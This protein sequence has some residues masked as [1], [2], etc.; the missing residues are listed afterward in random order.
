MRRMETWTDALTGLYNSCL[1][2]PCRG[3]DSPPLPDTA[4]ERPPL[5]LLYTEYQFFNQR[6]GFRRPPVA[7]EGH[8]SAEWNRGAITDRGQNGDTAHGTTHQVFQRVQRSNQHSHQYQNNNVL[9]KA[10]AP[11]VLQ[12]FPSSTPR[13][14]PRGPALSGWCGEQWSH[15]S[16]GYLSVEMDAPVGRAGRSSVEEMA[17][18]DSEYFSPRVTPRA[19]RRQDASPRQQRRMWAAPGPQASQQRHI[20]AAPGPQA[21]PLDPAQG[22]YYHSLPAPRS[23][24]L[25]PKPR[26]CISPQGFHISVVEKPTSMRATITPTSPDASPPSQHHFLPIQQHMAMPPANCPIQ[27]PANCPIQQHMAMPPSNCPIQQHMAMPPANCPIQQHMAMPPANC[28]IQQHMAVPPANR[29]PLHHWPPRHSASGPQ[30][31]HRSVHQPA[32][33]KPSGHLR[34]SVAMD[35]LAQSE[36]RARPTEGHSAGNSA[37][38]TRQVELKSKNVLGEPLLCATLKTVPSPPLA[39]RTRVQED[40]RKL[41]VVGD[42]VD[43]RKVTNLDGTLYQCPVESADGPHSPAMSRPLDSPAHTHTRASPRISRNGFGSVCEL[44]EAAVWSMR[45]LG[46]HGLF[47]P[48]GKRT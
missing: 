31:T 15:D 44:S 23:K 1:T 25:L 33:V 34:S 8:H 14:R 43:H 6:H 20:W 39:P 41:L 24:T 37:G 13:G 27:P 47:P 3:R 17:D 5:P 22:F 10:A 21:P 9:S 26:L 40:L 19:L 29:H 38:R 36:H 35:G 32:P 11:S 16:E 48:S 46:E 45:P 2:A 30:L 7:Q 42:T 18:S 4:P 28:P 12:L